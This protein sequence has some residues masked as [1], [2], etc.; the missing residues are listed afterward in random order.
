MRKLRN[1]LGPEPRDEQH[2]GNEYRGSAR[3]N[4]CTVPERPGQHARIESCDGFVQPLEQPARYPK[5]EPEQPLGLAENPGKSPDAK[6]NDSRKTACRRVLF[7]VLVT[8]TRAQRG[9]HWNQCQRNN[10]G[11]NQ[12]KSDG[13]CLVAKQLSRYAANEDHREKDRNSGKCCGGDGAG[14]LSSSVSGGLQGAFTLFSL[15]KDVFEHDDGVVDQHAYGQSDA[16]ER[17]DVERYIVR[18]HQQK[19]ADDRNRNRDRDDRGRARVSKESVQ[20]DNCENAAEN[21][22]RCHIVDCG[23]NEL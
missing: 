5:D 14:D 1:Q 7:R 9:Q 11:K 23:G 4:Y 15:P 18:V 13:Q 10:K 3:K 21:C 6:R 16:A 17:H 19:S 20:Y 8:V 12:R 22:R 2:G